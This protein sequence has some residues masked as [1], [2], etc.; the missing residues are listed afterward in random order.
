MNLQTFERR[1]I[2]FFNRH[3]P[4]NVDMA[5][6]IAKKY[7]GKEEQTFKA[8]NKYYLDKPSGVSREMTG[9]HLGSFMGHNTGSVPA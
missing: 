5:K 3:D 4:A 9:E 6:E 2:D 1:L 8:L 7:A